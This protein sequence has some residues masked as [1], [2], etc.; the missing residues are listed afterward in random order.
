MLCV[1][2]LVLLSLLSC[3]SVFGIDSVEAARR[4]SDAKT[5]LADAYEKVASAESAGGNVTTLIGLLNQAAADLDSANVA[6]ANG[7]FDVAL[8]NASECVL[9]ATAA[10]SDAV[11]LKGQATSAANE[12]WM[13]VL[14]SVLGIVIFSII[15]YGVW[16]WFKRTYWRRVLLSKPEVTD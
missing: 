7:E 5:S 11:Q 2:A 13:T 3:S 8:A 15:L 16:R 12:Q 6:Y 1:I 4:I 14:Y 9:Y 10:G